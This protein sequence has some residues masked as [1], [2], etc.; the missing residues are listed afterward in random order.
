MV[1]YDEA[2]V[3]QRSYVHSTPDTILIKTPCLVGASCDEPADTDHPVTIW[4][5]G[6]DAVA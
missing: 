6:P 5:K 4:G 3:N 2:I 1:E